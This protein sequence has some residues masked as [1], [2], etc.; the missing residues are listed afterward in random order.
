[1]HYGKSTPNYIPEYLHIERP[2]SFVF[3]L[4]IWLQPFGKPISS[5]DQ[6]K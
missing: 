2:E 1:M 3:V 5:V 4:G 6:K